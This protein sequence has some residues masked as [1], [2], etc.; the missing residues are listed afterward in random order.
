MATDQ[1]DNFRGNGGEQTVM[2]LNARLAAGLALATGLVLCILPAGAQATDTL[3]KIAVSEEFRI[4][5]RLGARPFSFQR[6][7][8]TVTG[9]TMDLCNEV[10]KGVKAAINRPNLKV[11]LVPV[12]ADDRFD[13]LSS[14]DIDILCGAT[15]NTLER[16]ARMDFSS[17]TFVTGATLLTRR[18]T[19]INTLTDT[20]LRSVGILPG[21]TTETALKQVAA[22]TGT[23]PKLVPVGDHAEALE[24]LVSGRI[25]AYASD[26]TI[27]IGLAR[28]SADA[29]MLSMA[30][31]LFSHE[32][33]ALALRP[34]DHA[35]RNV[36][37]RA[38]SDVYGSPKITE[39][40]GRWFGAMGARPSELL[41]SLY[42]LQTF[43]D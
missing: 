21:T 42:V 18:D 36:V 13:R 27:L 34:N 19:G 12:H 4:G 15:T 16:Q 3:Q 9:Y 7:D 8:G 28:D 25:D 32:P 23:A 5:H 35:F 29:G 37:N 31:G 14:G 17:L 24:M 2:R 39:I 22:R 41:R 6:E 26:R 40:Y 33:Y 38:L 1:S 20:H 30:R 43:P 11:T 10:T